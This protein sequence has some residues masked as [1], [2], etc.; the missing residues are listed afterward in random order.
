M[1]AGGELYRRLF[2]SSQEVALRLPQV[3]MAWRKIDT[4][5]GKA[6]KIWHAQETLQ[7]TRA[8][9]DYICL[10]PHYCFLDLGDKQKSWCLQHRSAPFP[11]PGLTKAEGLPDGCPTMQT[12][13]S[14]QL[15]ELWPS[16]VLNIFRAQ[17]ILLCFCLPNFAHFLLWLTLTQ[18]VQ[19]RK[20]WEM[21]QL[22][23]L[24]A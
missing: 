7:P 1:G 9:R 8:N 3:S 6:R 15:G 22:N 21:F 14:A 24:R 4:N 23:Y 10:S 13:L 2:L 12:S 11:G 5:Q 18:T 17:W 19:R 20:F 16:L